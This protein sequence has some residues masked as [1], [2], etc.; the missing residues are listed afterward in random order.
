MEL[1]ITAAM[2]LTG[3]GKVLVPK[4]VGRGLPKIQW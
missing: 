4:T 3:N 2:M 1:S